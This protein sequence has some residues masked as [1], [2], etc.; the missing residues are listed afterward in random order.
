M[1]P[2]KKLQVQLM[3]RSD[4]SG[5]RA[6]NKRLRILGHLHARLRQDPSIPNLMRLI[7]AADCFG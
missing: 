4:K 7:Y 3:N 6:E 2:K 5:V 1:C